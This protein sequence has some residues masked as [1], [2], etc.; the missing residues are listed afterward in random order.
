MPAGWQVRDERT[1]GVDSGQAAEVLVGLYDFAS[2]ERYEARDSAG[3]PW[4]DN[5]VRLKLADC[6]Y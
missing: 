2:G 3:E 1:L 5:A 6:A 4:P